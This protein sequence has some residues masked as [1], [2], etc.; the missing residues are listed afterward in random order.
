M[1]ITAVN[2]GLQVYC[3]VFTWI[4]LIK[5]GVAFI[6][7]VV[8]L[9]SDFEKLPTDF[10]SV[11]LFICP[12]PLPYCLETPLPFPIAWKEFTSLFTIVVS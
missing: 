2:V 9:P 8:D 4:I 11:C 7:H 5:S 3:N 12:S 10:Q 6:G 1:T